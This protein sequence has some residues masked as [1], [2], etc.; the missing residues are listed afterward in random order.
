LNQDPR[1]DR[2]EVPEDAKAALRAG[3]AAEARRVSDLQHLARAAGALAELGPEADPFDLIAATVHEMTDHTA[4]VAV[5]EI[6][7]GSTRYRVRAAAGV[8]DGLELAT[9]VLGGDPRQL[10][11]RVPDT[12]EEVHRSPSLARLG[13]GLAALSRGVFPSGAA[14]VLERALGIRAVYSI[15]FAR[16]GVLYGNVAVL[17]RDE[18]A[19][20]VPLIEAFAGQVAVALERRQ[21]ALRERSL[22]E[23]LRAV[24][25]LAD[26]LVEAESVDDLCRQAVELARERLGLERCSIFLVDGEDL[27]GTRGTDLDR[28]TTDEHHMVLSERPADQ[29]A[30]KLAERVRQ[31]LDEPGP[32]G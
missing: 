7:D 6:L 17:A 25:E 10:S 30:L 24:A 20:N 12:A 28:R 26:E 23:G 19:V 11:G 3:Q 18:S 29:W 4:L 27:R 9:K 13:G 8:G 5:T 31:A 1:L 15:S 21:A 16:A 32:A 2:P 14:Q 22:A